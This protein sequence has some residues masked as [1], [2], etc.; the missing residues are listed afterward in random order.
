MP[1]N[2]INASVDGPA[3]L[4]TKSGISRDSWLERAVATGR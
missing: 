4:R 2:D 3:M 1:E